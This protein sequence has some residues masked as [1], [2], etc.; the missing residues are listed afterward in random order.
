LQTS[1]GML[2]LDA[3]GSADGS[4]MPVLTS[5]LLLV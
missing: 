5:L 4:T 3:S 2:V 1:V